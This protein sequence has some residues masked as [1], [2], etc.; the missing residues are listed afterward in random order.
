M[1]RPVSLATNSWH[2]GGISAADTNYI[3]ENCIAVHVGAPVWEQLGHTAR[4]KRPVTL[5]TPQ[6]SPEHKR[7]LR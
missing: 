5:L 4:P 7:W 2:Y 3:E 1:A 6:A